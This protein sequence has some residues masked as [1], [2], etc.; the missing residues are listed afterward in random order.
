[1]VLLNITFIKNKFQKT[2]GLGLVDLKS[3]FAQSVKSLEQK[4]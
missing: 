4:N 3:T 2:L 1:M